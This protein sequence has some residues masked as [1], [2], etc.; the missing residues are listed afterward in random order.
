MYGLVLDGLSIKT[1]NTAYQ[2]LVL[3]W[4][5]CG[6]FQGNAPLLKEKLPS[7]TRH[8]CNQHKH[9]DNVHYRDCEHAELS[10]DTPWLQEDSLVQF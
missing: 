9:D 4:L 1:D 7:V 10:A 6:N 5:W 2:A 8:M 3:V